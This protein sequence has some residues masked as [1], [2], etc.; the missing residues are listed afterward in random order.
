MKVATYNRK[1]VYSDHSDSV[2]NQERMCRDHARLR[3]GDQIESFTAYQ[4]EGF[5]GA[6]TDRPGLKRLLSDIDA[7]KI[8][9]LVVYQLDRLSRSVKDFAEIYD[10][11]QKKG[12]AFVSV[13]EQMDT[14]TPMGRAMINITMVFAQMERETIAER[15]SDNARGLAMKGFW[16]GGK[17]PTGYRT[18]P[19]EAGGKE[20]FRLEP[21][22]AEAGYVRRIYRDFLETGKATGAL[23]TMYRAEGIKSIGGRPVRQSQIWAILTKP[24]YC[25][26]TKEA[27]DYWK[28]KGC[29][30]QGPGRDAWDGEHGVMAYGRKRKD[31]HKSSMRD[32]GDW[33]ISLGA[34]EPLI[35]ASDWIAVQKRLSM[36]TFSKDGGCPPPLLKGVARCAFCGCLLSVRR[37]NRRGRTYV[38]YGCQTRVYMGKEACQLGYVKA[39]RLDGLVMDKLR[40]AVLDPSVLEGCPDGLDRDDALEELASVKKQE[41]AMAKKLR[42]L[43]AA[44]SEAEGSPARRYILEEMGRADAE[45]CRLEEERLGLEREMEASAEREKRREEGRLTLENFISSFEGMTA[46]QKNRVM[47]GLIRSCTWD[48][49]TLTIRM[50]D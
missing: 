23:A 22:D 19:A 47:R 50:S 4:D 6:N 46:E 20:H 5:T 21:V 39:D 45:R 8:D 28:A 48:G 7:G 16:L 11:F 26:A 37:Q 18:V 1:S 49:E 34:H 44:L 27:Y 10:R 12:V 9:A 42:N 14:E 15:V 24:I 41:E 32:P 25:Q 36:N 3:F 13:K 30:I 33:V 31:G 40:K 38:S 17:P 2:A 35:P 43:A 29:E